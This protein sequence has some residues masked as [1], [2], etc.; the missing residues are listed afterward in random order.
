MDVSTLLSS[1]DLREDTDLEFKSARGGVPG[2]MW[3]TYSGMANTD[4]GVILLGIENDGTI[5]GLPDPAKAR[6]TVWDSLNNRG[7][8]SVNLLSND[9]VRVVPVAEKSVLV[10]EV[11]RA[12]RRQRPGYI[13]QNPITGTFRRNFEGDY[14]CTPDE[15]G[16]MLAD[17]SEEPADS[18]ILEHLGIDEIDP[19]S[20]QQYR[21]R[22]S[23][24]A[25]DHPWLSLDH[26]GLLSRLGGWRRD[27]M[28]HKEGLTI[29]GLLM[30]GKDEAIRDALAI[31][32]YHVDYRE[33][34]STDPEVRWTD[35]ITVD[36][37][38]TANLFQF[39]QRVI[40]KLF[41]DLKVPFQLQPDMFRKDETLVHEAIREALVN[42]LIH[43]DY[44]GQGGIIIEKYR[45][46]ITMSNPGSL[47]LPIEQLYQGGIS[48]CRN[49][50]L[51]L[52]FQQIGGGEKAGSGID[53]IRQG[54]ASQKWRL[55]LIR[56]TTR[57][58]RVRIVLPMISLLPQTS[59]DKLQRILGS[60]FGGLGPEEIQALVTADVEGEVSN[61]RLRQFSD[62]HTTNITKRLQNLVSKGFLE[63]DG[64]GRAATYSLAGPLTASITPDTTEADSG[65]I[66]ANSG[67]KGQRSGH[68]DNQAPNIDPEKA[69]TLLAI[70]EPARQTSRLKPEKMQLIIRRLCTDRFLTFRQLAALL[71]RE[72][73]GLQR[74][75]LRPMAQQGQLL[76]RYP[77]TPNHPRQAYRTNPHWVESG[78]PAS[79]K[80]RAG[81]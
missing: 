30:F 78:G 71:K 65:Q 5:S 68:T 56:E 25:P 4:G 23:A 6:K 63:K 1:L 13:G 36:G 70:A 35:R 77:E 49:K 40:I 57:P 21:Q 79:T 69:P 62:H 44:R 33:R 31:P 38:W 51:Q 75:T 11:P 10:M 54:W 72:P 14:R 80:R 18:R 9:Q 20:L 29:A 3:D 32:Q 61:F 27:G 19:T 26:R 76:L 74:W 37:T 55:P 17:Q 22:F 41:S 66:E 73:G 53:K 16:R 28:T 43:A 39:Y 48:E 45:D 8:V 47:L 64:Y 52:M 60:E 50:S 7:Q 24:R 34:L 2:S 15:V 81:T 46:R 59:V 58:D 42:A 67:H 12:N